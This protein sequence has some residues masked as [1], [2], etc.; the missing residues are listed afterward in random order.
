MTFHVMHAQRRH[1]P[2]VGEASAERGADQQRS[3]QPRTGGIGHRVDVGGSG[4][5]LVQNLPHQRRQPPHVITRGK[6]RYHAS[7]FGMD[8]ALRVHG[9]SEQTVR[10]VVNRNAGLVAGGLDPE[11]AHPST[12]V[13]VDV[14]S[15]MTPEPVPARNRWSFGS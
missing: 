2:R 8:G 4:A 1:P 3:H 14:Q 11:D 12:H 15:T 10:G 5:G 13:H 6:L 7:E 9:M